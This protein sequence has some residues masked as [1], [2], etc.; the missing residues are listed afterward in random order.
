MTSGRESKTCYL[1]ERAMWEPRKTDNRLFVEAVLYWN[2]CGYSLAWLTI[3][4]WGFSCDAHSLSVDGQKHACG[5]RC[6]STQ[7][8]D[9][10]NEYAMIDK[11]GCLCPS[12]QRRCEG[13]DASTEAIGRSSR[14]IKYQDSCC[15]G[16]AGQLTQFPLDTWVS[17]RPWWNWPT[18]TQHCCWHSISRQRL[19]CGWAS[20]WEA[21]GT[22]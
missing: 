10:D 20:N 19:W 4:I 14:R 6:L 11:G 3:L 1:G 12:T 17:L 13:G 22:G 21:S 8:D 9:A 18:V 5:S 7:A 2:P 16:C 15:G